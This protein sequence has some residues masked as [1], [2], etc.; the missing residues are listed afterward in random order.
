[1]SGLR[2]ALEALREDWSLEE[3][4]REAI[5]NAEWCC[6]IGCGSGACESCPC[7]CAGYCVSGRDG[8]S[9][10]LLRHQCEFARLGTR[11][12]KGQRRRIGKKKWD[13]IWRM[14]HGEAERPMT[15]RWGRDD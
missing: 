14:Y 4:V 10:D 7:C 5:R 8:L 1:M 2:E 12:L 6:E 15:F 9:E 11:I 13:E 3:I